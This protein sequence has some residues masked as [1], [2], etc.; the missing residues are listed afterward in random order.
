MNAYSETP[1][2]RHTV[3]DV[4]TENR[5]CACCRFCQDVNESHLGHTLAKPAEIRFMNLS[6]HYCVNEFPLMSS[7]IVKM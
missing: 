3:C 7:H 6:I 4:M 5:I 2:T 1:F